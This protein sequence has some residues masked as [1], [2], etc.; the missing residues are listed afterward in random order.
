M[1]L[2][3]ILYLLRIQ[4][5]EYRLLSFQ[6][7]FVVAFLVAGLLL[8]EV[9]TKGIISGINR[10]KAQFPRGQLIVSPKH[11]NVSGLGLSVGKLTDDSLKEISAIKGV[12]AVNPQMGLK[13]PLRAEAEMMGQRAASDIVLIGIDEAMVKD[14]ISPN[15][16]FTYDPAKDDAIP[17]MV[18]ALFFDLFNLA[19]AESIGFPKLNDKFI[20]GRKFTL[21]CGESLVFGPSAAS[22]AMADSV[23][24]CRIVG[25]CDVPGLT[26]GGY[27]PLSAA[28]YLNKRN[29]QPTD[30]YLK[31]LVK[32]DPVLVPE[33]EKAIGDL[34]FMVE[35]NRAV[36]DRIRFAS[37]VIIGLIV[38]FAVTVLTIAFICLFNLYTNL[39]ELRRQDFGL[40]RCVGASQAFILF[41]CVLETLLRTILAGVLGGGLTYLGLVY[42]NAKLIKVL[43]QVSFLPTVLLPVT[44]TDVVLM[45]LAVTVLCL[46]ISFQRISGICRTVPARLIE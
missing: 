45:I 24:Q 43:P 7:I 15:Y 18:P 26:S 1:R 34:G 44:V 5:R 33:I 39:Y 31:A 40:M 4:F 10:A 20:T 30:V 17:V 16:R 6:A 22:A 28:K 38:V 19:Y 27:I 42:A 11:I 29:K 25:V 35:S 23:Y 9:T 46:A 37:E 2:S 12:E 13:V 36:L 3:G 8:T 41:F 21:Y 14:K 32:T